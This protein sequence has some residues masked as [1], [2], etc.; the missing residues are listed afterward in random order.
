[1]RSSSLAVR[2]ARCPALQQEGHRTRTGQLEAHFRAETPRFHPKAECAQVRTDGFVECKRS[3]TSSRP[4]IARATALPCVTVQ[5]ELAHCQDVPSHLQDT[6][7][8][9]SVLTRKDA[10]VSNLL[11]YI[12]RIARGVILPDADQN[13]QP[14]TD[15]P[16][17]LFRHPH[18]RLRDPLHHCPHVLTIPALP[19]AG[20]PHSPGGILCYAFGSGL[21]HLTRALALARRLA[22]LTPAP[23]E[24]LTHSPF[25]NDPLPGV[26][27]PGSRS[28]ILP[29]GEP[30]VR[31]TQFP[32]ASPAELADRLIAHL[33]TAPPA[34][35]VVDAFPRGILGE[36]P[37]VLHHVACPR[38]LLARRVQPRWLS[39]WAAFRAQPEPWDLV[40]QVEPG[41]PAFA[42]RR[43]EQV[44]P[45]LIRDRTE[46]PS[47]PEARRGL[48]VEGAK[49]V[50]CVVSGGSADRSDAVLAL[51]R[52]ALQRAGVQA[53]LIHAAR[54]TPGRLFPPSWPL[55][56]W[57]PA[58]D[59]VIGEAGYHL[60]HETA[61]TGTPAL[62]LPACRRYDDPNGRAG[63]RLV[64]SPDDFEA[65]IRAILEPGD[66]IHGPGAGD[67]FS[68][69]PPVTSGDGGAARAAQLVAEL[70]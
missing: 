41:A 30:S 32:T 40:L 15:R 53:R 42:T 33:R 21:G 28:P 24:I 6:P 61:L 54:A 67:G 27:T 45:V 65:R 48:G 43:A 11:C 60:A 2:S 62:F 58:L 8:H 17:P 4:R 26:G 3:R 47:R 68:A 37:G 34:L 19:S 1:M 55:M 59:L 39:H 25:P 14:G 56:E 9:A 16:H 70:L 46:L 49:P 66:G 52:T 29:D 69:F 5:R 63:N 38:V 23:F 7:V 35:L 31:L 50:V 64:R 18:R 36:L 57:L 20:R 51:T 13:H 44:E 12:H 22:P 10:E